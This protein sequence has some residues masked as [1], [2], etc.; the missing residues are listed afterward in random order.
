MKQE[1]IQ[2]EQPILDRLE[3]ICP[4]WTEYL[5][6]NPEYSTQ[7]GKSRFMHG[8]RIMDTL[9][10]KSCFVGEAHNFPDNSVNYTGV[11]NPVMYDGCNTCFTFST[12]LIHETRENLE[13]ILN[14]FVDHWERF[15][16][17]IQ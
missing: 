5:R 8:N 13:I 9:N 6:K 1:L 12:N 15:H 14:H 7:T 16:G 11:R 4:I 2:V 10:G 17:D 3:K